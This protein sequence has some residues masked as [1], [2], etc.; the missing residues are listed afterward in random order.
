MEEARTLVEVAPCSPSSIAI[1]AIFCS[2]RIILTWISQ[3]DVGHFEGQKLYLVKFE[4]K[5][6]I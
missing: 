4:D 6:E 2:K 1:R 5:V 3:E